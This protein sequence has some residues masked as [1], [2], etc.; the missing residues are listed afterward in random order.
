MALLL[1]AGCAARDRHL[2]GEEG[3]VSR[4]FFKTCMGVIETGKQLAGSL[5]ASQLSDLEDMCGCQA[6]L[7]YKHGLFVAE[8]PQSA[9]FQ[10][11]AQGLTSRVGESQ[12]SDPESK[13]MSE[14]AKSPNKLLPLFFGAALLGGG[15]ILLLHL[16]SDN[17]G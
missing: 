4:E 16:N 10:K 3:T 9:E 11:C 13:T 6:E 7:I 14:T 1:V 15:L 12:S 5:R 17:D 8:E 2:I